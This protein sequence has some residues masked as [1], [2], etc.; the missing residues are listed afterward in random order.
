MIAQQ[1]PNASGVRRN[2]DTGCMAIFFKNKKNHSMAQQYDNIGNDCGW[3]KEY[4]IS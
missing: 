3:Q 2:I 4:G 1:D